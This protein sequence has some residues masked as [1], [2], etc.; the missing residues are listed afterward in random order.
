MYTYTCIHIYTCMC[1]YICMC[2]Y[3]YIYIYYVAP[4]EGRRLSGAAA[5][6]SASWRTSNKCII[7]YVCVCYMYV[8]AYMYLVLFIERYIIVLTN[9]IMVSM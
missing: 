7:I 3:I 8:Y 6:C 5:P 4:P 2:T 9:T 1:V